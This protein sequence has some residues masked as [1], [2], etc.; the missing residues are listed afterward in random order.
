MNIVLL[1]SAVFGL[2]QP[3]G[4]SIVLLYISYK[5]SELKFLNETI[6]EKLF[7][8]NEFSVISSSLIFELDQLA[9]LC[10]IFIL[11]H[12]PPLSSVA[13]GIL[14][15]TISKQIDGQITIEHL[16]YKLWRGSAEVENIAFQMPGIQVKVA[17][18]DI[19]FALGKGISIK[20]EYPSVLIRSGPKT[21]TPSKHGASPSR[22]WTI[23]KQF[24]KLSIEN[25]QFDWASNSMR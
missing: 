5:L 21:S 24:E 4:R 14:T 22:F 23:L 1:P 2:I 11:I 3:I 13:K 16:N 12:L 25:G 7:C 9:S 17:R 15:R 18:V 19:S 8:T 6:Y 10:L 20:A